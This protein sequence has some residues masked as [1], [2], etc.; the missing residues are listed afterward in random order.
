MATI[1]TSDQPKSAFMESLTKVTPLV[2]GAIAGCVETV[3][4]MPFEV[5][6][7]LAPRV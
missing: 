7:L 4:C 2:A 6:M 3:V 5:L 1:S